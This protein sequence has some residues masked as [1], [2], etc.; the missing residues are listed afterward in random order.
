MDLSGSPFVPTGDIIRDICQRFREL[1]ASIRV[2]VA[3]IVE[4]E[5]RQAYAQEH[6]YI[7]TGRARD[8]QERT[9]K[10]DPGLPASEQAASLGLHRTTIWRNIRRR[11]A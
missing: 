2:E 10:I 4:R 1:D 9:A 8:L 11:K 6:V 7:A 5:A 3:N